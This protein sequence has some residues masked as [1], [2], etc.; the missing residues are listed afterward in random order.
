MVDF[1]K[2]PTID[3]LKEHKNF[4]SC[5]VIGKHDIIATK[6]IIRN[7]KTYSIDGKQLKESKIY[8]YKF[9]ILYN[10]RNRWITV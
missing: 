8:Y 10:D 3:Q 4:L 5:V 9:D 7:R 1:I 6:T 2:S